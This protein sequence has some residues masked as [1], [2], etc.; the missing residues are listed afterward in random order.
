MDTRLWE[1]INYFW[2]KLISIPPPMIGYKW[3]YSSSLVSWSMSDTFALIF[4]TFLVLYL[5]DP[6]EKYWQLHTLN[7]QIVSGITEPKSE[8]YL[9]RHFLVT[10]SEY[11]NKL[12]RYYDISGDNIPQTASKTTEN[13]EPYHKCMDFSDPGWGNTTLT[14]IRSCFQV[15]W[16][17]STAPGSG[18][19]GSS[20]Y[21]DTSKQIPQIC[22]GMVYCWGSANL[23]QQVETLQKGSRGKRGWTAER[24]CASM[25]GRSEK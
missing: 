6:I 24:I 25:S 13:P 15:L 5:Q 14:E 10:S 20:R 7:T 16:T 11:W 3:V 4:P 19:M 12:W 9:F 17:I 22:T 1:T 23:N 18:V 2:Q 21:E 8:K